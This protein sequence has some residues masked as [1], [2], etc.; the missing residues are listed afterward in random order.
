MG[1]ED[2]LAEPLAEE[3]LRFAVVERIL[4]EPDD[5]EMQLRE[6]RAHV[7][8]PVLRLHE[9]L[10]E[11]IGNRPRLLLFGQR[12][13]VALAAPVLPRSA[14]PLIED[15][16]SVEFDTVL[17]LSDE[18]RQFRIAFVRPKLVGNIEGD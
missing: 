18:I 10:V 2:V 17:Q 14:Y 6:R 15:P 1:V 3:D 8:E 13:E 7:V 4:D 11:P 5:V 12:P 9:D 16:A